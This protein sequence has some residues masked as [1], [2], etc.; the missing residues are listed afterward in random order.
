MHDADTSLSFQKSHCVQRNLGSK[1]L[2]IMRIILCILVCF[3]PSSQGAYQR[4]ISKAVVLVRNDIQLIFWNASAKSFI[5]YLFI[6]VHG[7]MQ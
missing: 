4:G 3:E 7:T 5:A 2:E 1:H 6:C